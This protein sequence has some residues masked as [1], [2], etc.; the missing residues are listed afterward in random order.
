[1]HGADPETPVSGVSS[2]SMTH[3][4]VFETTLGKLAETLDA[5]PGTEPLMLLYGLRPAPEPWLSAPQV[6]PSDA[7]S[8]QRQRLCSG[9][10]GAECL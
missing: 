6:A 5:D 8:P 10:A 4:K 9:G 2:A 1:M 7:W 3:Q